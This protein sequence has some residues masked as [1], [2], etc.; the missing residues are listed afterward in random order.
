MTCTLDPLL[1]K[2]WV[3]QPALPHI[4]SNISDYFN[5]SLPSIILQKTT[6]L[7]FTQ[8]SLGLEPLIHC[9]QGNESTTQHYLILSKKFLTNWTVLCPASF[10]KRHFNSFLL[11]HLYDLNLGFTGC[12]AMSQPPSMSSYFLSDF[13]RGN[14]SVKRWVFLIKRGMQQFLLWKDEK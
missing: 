9:L 10:Y 8:K 6:F 3:N 14:T 12:K 13:C 7:S 4:I 11:K 5:S 1:A 2:W